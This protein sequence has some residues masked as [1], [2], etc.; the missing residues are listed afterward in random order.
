MDELTAIKQQLA[1][2][3]ET[4]NKVT[5]NFKT[6]TIKL[7]QFSQNLIFIE[8]SMKAKFEDYDK[9]LEEYCKKIESKAA[10]DFCTFLVDRLSH[11]ESRL[12]IMAQKSL[13]VSLIKESYSK[14][15]NILIH[16]LPENLENPW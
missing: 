6:I 7:D 1:E 11:V 15:M 2:I 5:D 4:V 3:F 13:K 16:G 9:K 8:K 10:I 12:D 14:R